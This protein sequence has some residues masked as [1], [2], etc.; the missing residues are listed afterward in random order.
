[1]RGGDMP[2]RIVTNKPTVPS[3]NEESD[4]GVDK[5]RVAWR[6][7]HRDPTFVE[8]VQGK[9]PTS[10]DKVPD[11]VRNA[12]F[13][14]DPSG[15]QNFQYDAL[16]ALGIAMC[17]AG[18]NTTFFT[19]DD[20]YGQFRRLDFEG[21]SG[22]NKILNETGTRSYTTI[23][24][25]A[26]NVRITD[27]VSDGNS[28]IEYVPSYFLDGE[29]WREVPGNAFEFADGSTTAPGSI[30][31]VAFNYNYIGTPSRAVAWSFM[32]ITM[33]AAV[34]ALVWAIYYRANH[35]VNSAQPLFLIMAAVGAFVM[36][37]SIVPLSLEEAVT[38][39]QRSLNA[40]CML[41]PWLYFT[42]AG[43]AVSGLLAKAKA[44]HKV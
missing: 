19:G 12:S 20:I 39:S 3:Y 42:G 16:T 26:W 17:R 13:S 25:I 11:F 7:A 22:R 21:A 32:A 43:I 41:T 1:M 24:F 2:D 27:E 30:P 9:L 40:S 6:N 34:A 33:I 37:S 28:V 14:D 5:F 44:V 8:Y 15:F 29:S 36:V 4:S 18:A 35:V 31:P 38:T 10:L 23:A